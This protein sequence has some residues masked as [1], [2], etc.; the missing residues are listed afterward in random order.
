MR[1]HETD[2]LREMLMSRTTALDAAEQVHYISEGKG[3]QEYVVVCCNHCLT[4][5]DCNDPLSMLGNGEPQFAACLVN[6][7]RDQYVLVQ[8]YAASMCN[9]MQCQFII[10]CSMPKICI[11]RFQ[12]QGMRKC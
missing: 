12:M 4:A 1:G 9:A 3:G 2:E 8:I 6:I 7:L 11:C 10:L 5:G